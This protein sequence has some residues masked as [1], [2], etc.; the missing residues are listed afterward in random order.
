[1]FSS[2]TF[3]IRLTAFA[4]SYYT[5]KLYF[6]FVSRRDEVKHRIINTVFL[7]F[8]G[9]FYALWI[10]TIGDEDEPIIGNRL[11]ISKAVVLAIIT[12]S[13]ILL[14]CRREIK[15]RK[16]I[17]DAQTNVIDKRE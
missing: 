3:Y 4:A 12:S 15:A 10:A 8:I 1:M 9:L 14:G 11:W 5:P 6:A 16:I 17:D 2:F 7:L 13:G